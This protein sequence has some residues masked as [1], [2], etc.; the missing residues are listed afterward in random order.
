MELSLLVN[1]RVACRKEYCLAECGTSKE[2]ECDDVFHQDCGG[3]GSERLPAIQYLQHVRPHIRRIAVPEAQPVAALL[4]VA[5]GVV[6]LVG[7]HGSG[8]FLWFGVVLAGKSGREQGKSGRHQSKSRPTARFPR[9]LPPFPCPR[10]WLPRLPPPFPDPAKQR[11]VPP[12]TDICPL[13]GDTCPPARDSRPAKTPL[14]P[15]ALNPFNPL[16]RRPTHPAFR[17]AFP[18][19]PTALNYARRAM[20]VGVPNAVSGGGSQAAFLG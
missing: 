15:P 8:V 14:F 17:L 3:K 20:R 4:A 6:I 12:A 7:G 2:Q 9:L 11:K 18:R 19:E 1:Q 13:A 5:A 10:K 16:L